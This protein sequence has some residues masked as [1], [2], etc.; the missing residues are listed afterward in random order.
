MEEIFGTKLYKEFILP[1]FE[2]RGEDIKPEL[3]GDFEKRVCEVL[4]KYLSD[5][6]K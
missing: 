4:I 2:K 3:E 1:S 5:G 6:V